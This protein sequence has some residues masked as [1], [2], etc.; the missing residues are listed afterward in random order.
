MGSRMAAE[1][2][3]HYVIRLAVVAAS[4]GF[5]GACGHGASGTSNHAP[6]ESA[7]VAGTSSLGN[8]VVD[9]F[10]PATGPQLTI[11][12]SVY[13]AM[14]AVKTGITSRC[15]RRYGFHQA[16]WSAATAASLSFDNADFPDL[17]KMTHTGLF[18]SATLSAAQGPPRGLS[19]AKQRAYMADMGRCEISAEDVFAPLT[20]A[21]NALSNTWTKIISQTES[22]SPVLATLAGYRSCMEAA[23]VPPTS[24]SGL[25]T[26]QALGGFLAW[27]T[28]AETQAAGRAGEIAVERHWVPIFVRCATPT[29]KVQDSLLLARQREFL[30]AHSQQVLTVE[31]LANREIAL[32]IR[33]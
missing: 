30:R 1:N 14:M 29:V 9:Y 25:S 13:G 31:A 21:T 16:A 5:I 15:L 32:A 3:Q 10:F 23:G 11:G 28:G 2:G 20:E 8:D 26:S 19:A 27:E 7:Q 12:S 33:R 17:A 22:S 18:D 24:L 4:L 6:T